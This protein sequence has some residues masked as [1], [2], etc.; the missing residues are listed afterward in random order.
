[1]LALILL[2]QLPSPWIGTW[3]GTS[4]CLVHPSACHDE[5]V[6]YH[7]TRSKVDSTH[8]T[9]DA[10][11]IVNGAEEEMGALECTES[12]DHQTLTC[13]FQLGAWRLT[14]D[15]DRATGGLW[16]KDGSKFRAASVTRDAK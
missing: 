12:A 13:P 4:T 8:L 1:M 7:I 10:G 11:K 9:W 15:G 6:V 14:L 5:S 16:L 2:L 3:R